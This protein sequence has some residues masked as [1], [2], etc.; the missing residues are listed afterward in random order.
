VVRFISVEPSLQTVSGYR[1][2][3]GFT[4]DGGLPTSW[5]GA[6]RTI[7]MDIG[8]RVSVHDRHEGGFIDRTPFPVEA[9]PLPAE[10][11]TTTRTPIGGDAAVVAQREPEDHP[12]IYFRETTVNDVGTYWTRC[13]TG[14]RRATFRG[15]TD[16]PT[17]TSRIWRV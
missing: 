5:G 3:V 10:A 1:G 9:G 2:G 7:V 13:R 15:T 14:P 6:R 16:S 12:S 4:R 8:L 17:R 11:N